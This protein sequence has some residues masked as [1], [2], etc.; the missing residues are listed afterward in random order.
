MLNLLNNAVRFSPSQK[1]INVTLQ[2]EYNGITLTIRDHGPGIP[3]EDLPHIFNRY[4]RNPGPDNKEGLGLGLEIVREVVLAHRG[5]VQA[6]NAP[7]GG[8]EFEI[9]LPVALLID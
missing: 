3:A 8:A 9:I 2:F 5:Q 6:R 7:D 4:Y 1:Q